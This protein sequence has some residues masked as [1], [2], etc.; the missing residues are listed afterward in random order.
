MIGDGTNRPINEGGY[1]L[2]EFDNNVTAASDITFDV[3]A[4]GDATQD[5]DYYFKCWNHNNSSNRIKWGFN[6]Y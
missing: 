4:T 6:T 5:T 1:V 3:A 2:L